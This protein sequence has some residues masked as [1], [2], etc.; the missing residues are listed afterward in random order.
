MSF[1]GIDYGTRRVGIA[2]S[3]EG[4]TLAFPTEVVSRKDALSRIER[5]A[6]EREA[7]AIVLG[8]SK[9]YHDKDNPLMADI[10]QFAEELKQKTGLPIYLEPEFLTSAAAKSAGASDALLD[11]SA[12]AHILQSFLDTRR[13]G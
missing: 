11:A 4:N 8:E 13:A 2:I 6:H 7:K 5:L 10:L 12:A 1:L 9:D 3:D